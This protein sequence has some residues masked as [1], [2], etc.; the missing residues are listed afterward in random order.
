VD[1]IILEKAIANYRRLRRSGGSPHQTLSVNC[2]ASSLLDET[3]LKTLNELAL[4]QD[5]AFSFQL[6]Q[7]EISEKSAVPVDNVEEARAFRTLLKDLRRTLGL[8]FA[9]DDF[10]VGASNLAR[11]QDLPLS[12]VK[13]DRSM[14]YA[15]F[16]TDVIE[17]ARRIALEHSAKVVVEGWDTD[18]KLSLSDLRR[19]KVDGVQGFGIRKPALHL[20]DLTAAEIRHTG[21]WPISIAS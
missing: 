9:T 8:S 16:A 1:G 14:L 10:G 21:V 2:Y 6:L 15:D 19:Q 11:L 4:A 3:Y 7:L 17:L 13:I 20:H 18:C 5:E 12:T